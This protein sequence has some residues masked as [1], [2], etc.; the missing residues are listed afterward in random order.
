MLLPAT[1]KDLSIFQSVEHIN[2]VSWWGAGL[3]GD[4]VSIFFTP[5]RMCVCVCVRPF[6]LNMYVCMHASELVCNVD[7]LV[8]A[9]WA[10]Q[11]NADQVQP[12]R[13]MNVQ[14]TCQLAHR[15]TALMMRSQ[16]RL[17]RPILHRLPLPRLSFVSSLS[18]V[19]LPSSE[20]GGE[21][22]WTRASL[23]LSRIR[24]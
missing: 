2:L 22:L 12:K 20:R 11:N 4:F 15:P 9:Q 8:W 3:C 13:P 14:S 19:Q 10:P 21:I 24:R 1:N 16:L 6:P 5:L 23:D 7:C 17:L 18:L